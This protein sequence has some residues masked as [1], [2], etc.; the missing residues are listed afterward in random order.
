MN[1]RDEANPN[2]LG[3]ESGELGSNLMDHHFRVGAAGEYD[4]FSDKYFKGR[5]PNGIYIPRFRNV[6]D[7]TKRKD[8]VRGYGYQGGASRDSWSRSVQELGFGKGLKE[9]LIEP[10]KW[11]MGM[12]A[13]GEMLP[14][15][16]NRVFLNEEVKDIYGQSTLT[17]D[18]EFKENEW[19]M[20][21]DMADSAAEMLE[22]AGLTNVNTYDSPGAPGLGI[23]EMG[24]ARM[25]TSSKNSVL[26]KHN[27]VW[28]APN[29]YVTDG[30]C[31][32]S[33]SCVNPSLTYMA[34]TARACDHAYKELNKM[35]I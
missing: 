1:S 10:G 14:N 22:A 32:T 18:C 15:H 17:F 11:R 8:F 31:M 29:V 7:K 25:G 3:N 27:Q 9:E 21:K 13:F 20:R 2:G 30:A 12:T 16:E 19:A 34:L 5:R 26:N 33:A 35:N 6:D 23:H 4:G 24:T 28:S